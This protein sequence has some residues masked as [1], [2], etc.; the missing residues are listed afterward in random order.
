MQDWM[1]FYLLDVRF[2]DVVMV[3]VWLLRPSRHVPVSVRPDHRAGH[4][5]TQLNVVYRPHLRLRVLPHSRAS[6]PI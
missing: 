3:A 5:K 1:W 6:G 4:C 2:P